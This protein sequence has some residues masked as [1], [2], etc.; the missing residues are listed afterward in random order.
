MGVED[1]CARETCVATEAYDLWMITDSPDAKYN[2]YRAVRHKGLHVLGVPAGRIASPSPSFSFSLQCIVKHGR[3]WQ[4]L[5][6]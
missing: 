4:A 6:G 3:S 2:W 1:A 5:H